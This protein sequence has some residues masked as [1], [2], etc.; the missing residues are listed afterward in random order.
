M[1]TRLR[2]GW[3]L[4]CLDGIHILQGSEML[5]T[6][7]GSTQGNLILIRATQTTLPTTKESA[8]DNGLGV[9]VMCVSGGEVLNGEGSLPCGGL[10]KSFPA[11]E[12]QVW[13][14]WGS[15]ESVYFRGRKE[16][17]GPERW[18]RGP[19]WSS[20]QASWL[21]GPSTE[22]PLWTQYVGADSYRES[23][24]HEH[25][26]HRPFPGWNLCKQHKKWKG[27]HLPN[28]WKWV[29]NKKF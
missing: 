16:A 25:L 10:R 17:R 7:P 12:C 6:E 26:W 19:G 13:W 11:E 5:S 9:V 24:S 4:F 1:H 22:D 28:L 15:T 29:T 14:P 23:Q 27:C 20:R 8:Y 18:G 2:R 3:S 21:R